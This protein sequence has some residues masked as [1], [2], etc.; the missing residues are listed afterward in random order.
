MGDFEP[1]IQTTLIQN[2][3]FA[4]QEL[5]VADF[6]YEKSHPFTEEAYTVTG[7]VQYRTESD[8][9]IIHV[10][11]DSPSVS[12]IV[13]EINTILSDSA[14]ISGGLNPS[15]QGLW[16]FVT[17]ADGVKKLRVMW[18]GSL[19]D[20]QTLEQ[21]EKNEAAG[22]A[23]IDS[24]DLAFVHDDE[25]SFAKYRDNTLTLSNSS[26]TEYIVQIL[27]RDLWGDSP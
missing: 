14:S 17:S 16:R 10:D 24:A 6:E 20:Y 25:F 27:E 1:S 23:I 11:S 15:L 8:I 19:V 5:L 9:V 13:Y 22:E 3:P 21:E 26:D 4:D 2:H 18:E 12:D 7:H